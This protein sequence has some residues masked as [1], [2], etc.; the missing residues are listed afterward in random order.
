MNRDQIVSATYE[1]GRQMNEIKGEFG[2]ITPAAAEATEKT[3]RSRARIDHR[4]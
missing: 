1:A 4:H 2:V 3:Y